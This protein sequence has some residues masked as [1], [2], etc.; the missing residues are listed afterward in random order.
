MLRVRAARAPVAPATTHTPRLAAQNADTASSRNS[1]SL[2]GMRKKNEVGKTHISR[3]V[4]RAV[5]SDSSLVV[6]R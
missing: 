2:Y 1:D 6:S 5:R 3:T 4:V